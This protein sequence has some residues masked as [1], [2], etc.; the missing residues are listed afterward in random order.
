MV[1]SVVVGVVVGKVVGVVVSVVVS[2]IQSRSTSSFSTS[3][4][5]TL[6]KSSKNRLSFPRWRESSTLLRRRESST[7]PRF[8]FSRFPL[9]GNGASNIQGS[10]PDVQ[11][12]PVPL[13]D[14]I[15]GDQ[16]RAA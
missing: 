15:K 1:V 4:R 13:I 9:G 14:C 11:T 2:V 3:S 5:Y 16:R 7:F 6:N 12:A 10:A 8:N